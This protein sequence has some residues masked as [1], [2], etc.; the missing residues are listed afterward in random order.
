[1]FLP[2]DSQIGCNV[3]IG[4]GVTFTDDRPPVVS[5]A[6]P[7]QYHAEPPIVEDFASIGAGAVILPGVRI[8]ARARIGAGAVVTKDVP[9]ETHVRGEPA[10]MR[11]LSTQ[12][13]RT[14][15]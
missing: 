5:L 7:S 9:A 12:S 4:P 3:F 10:R 11:A 8:G 15:A 13:A 2:S 1:M 14:W 6:A